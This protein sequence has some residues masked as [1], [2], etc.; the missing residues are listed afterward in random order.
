M[1][2]TL[3]EEHAQLEADHWWFVGRR[4]IIRAVLARRLPPRQGNTILDVGCGSGG[5]LPMLAELGSVS[6]LEGD[7]QAVAHARETFSG[8]RVELGRIPDDVPRAGELD[9]VTAFDV[10]EHL[11]DDVGALT[12][13]RAAV[14]PGGCVVVTVPALQWLWSEHDLASH[15]KR[16]YTRRRLIDALRAADLRVTH[17]SYFNTLLFPAV[18][19]ARLVQRARPGPIE[20]HS[21]F[22][23]PSPWLNRLLARV[24]S[25]ERS[26][27]A[28]RGL[29]I[30]VSLIA[31]AR[32]DP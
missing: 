23:M 25:S 2:R 22:S 21:D 18:A 12:A 26:A 16:R 27:V 20:A 32:R 29:P 19:G 3:F 1:D 10:I 7:E 17:V 31:V 5:M 13:L 24:L 8:W 14:R 9:V 4:A 6:G 11:E 15:H 28:R 30:G